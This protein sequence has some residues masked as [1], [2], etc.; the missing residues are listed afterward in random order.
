MQKVAVVGF[1]FMG[2]THAINILKHES[3]KLVAIVDKDVNGIES[4]LTSTSGNFSTGNIDPTLLSSINKYSSIES[5]LE[6]EDLDAIHICVHTDLHYDLSKKALLDGLHV[7]LEK[8]MTLDVEKGEELVNL[9]ADN[10]AT[11]MVG[12]VLRFMSPYQKLKKW[13][14]YE[15]HGSLRFLSM[16]RFSGVPGWGQ[17]KEKQIA[18][19][20]SGGALFDLLIHDIDYV[21]YLFGSPDKIDSKY[22]PGALSDYDYISAF[23][24]YEK[25]GIKVKLEGGNT[26]HSTFP[27]QA[28]FMANFENSS[29]FYTT[30]KPDVIQVANNDEMKEVVADDGGDGFY[31][32]IAY[33]YECIERNIKPKKCLP[34]SSLET[35]KLCY[36]HLNK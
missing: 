4:K 27:F 6:S 33:F 21:N 30:L 3:L 26:F 2:I 29:V 32:E 16:F 15:T 19:G 5:C 8:P 34:E 35:I 1:G 28:G 12:H 10:N 7:F 14:D 17:W 20:S 13:I 24:E 36:R 31:N 11:F 22:M 23:W 9:A 18:Y 25:S